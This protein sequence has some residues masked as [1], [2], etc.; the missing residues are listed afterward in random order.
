MRNVDFA[1]I[2]SYFRFHKL[3]YKTVYCNLT[4]FISSEVTYARNITRNSTFGVQVPCYLTNSKTQIVNCG[5]T[6][7]FYQIEP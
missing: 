1:D 6:L 7:L 2:K 4:S 5:F 3:S